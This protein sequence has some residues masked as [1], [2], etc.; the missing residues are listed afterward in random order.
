VTIDEFRRQGTTSRQALDEGVL[1]LGRLE[2]AR[3]DNNP[4]FAEHGIFRL[5]MEGGK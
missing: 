4:N 3:L 5:T 1:K 2:V